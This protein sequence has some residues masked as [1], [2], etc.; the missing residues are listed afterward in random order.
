MSGIKWLIPLLLILYLSAM[1]HPPARYYT[2]FNPPLTPCSVAFQLARWCLPCTVDTTELR[3]RN[4]TGR[5]RHSTPLIPTPPVLIL[6]PLSLCS[7]S[8]YLRGCYSV[9]ELYADKLL[10]SG[11]ISLWFVRVFN[12]A[13]RKNNSRDG[14]M[15]LFHIQ[16]S[17]SCLKRESGLILM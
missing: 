17:N 9:E 1:T 13:V 7:S 10:P 15:L 4:P 2:P 5:R 6:R 16:L 11:K 12:S 14:C 3:G 8:L